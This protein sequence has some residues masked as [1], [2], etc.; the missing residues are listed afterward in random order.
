MRRPWWTTF[1]SLLSETATT[2]S[3]Y[4]QFGNRLVMSMF[5]CLAVT[6]GLSACGEGPASVSGADSTVSTL[7]SASA[8]KAA[9][10]P[11]EW[12]EMTAQAL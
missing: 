3:S 5:L 1:Q 7:T 9:G 6:F 8:T 10:D 11:T 4:T 2:M 12:S